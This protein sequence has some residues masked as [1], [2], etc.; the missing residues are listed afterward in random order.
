MGHLEPLVKSQTEA[1]R[2]GTGRPG[3][4]GGGGT[5]Q[6]GPFLFIFSLLWSR[7]HKHEVYHF[8]VHGSAASVHGQ[9]CAIVA[10]V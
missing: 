9:C 5:G 2:S 3:R 8:K 10:P 4:A 1:L 7:T 6:P